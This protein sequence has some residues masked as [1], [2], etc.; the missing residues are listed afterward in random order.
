MG[1][2]SGCNQGMEGISHYCLQQLPLSR[3]GDGLAELLPV[4][5]AVLIPPETEQ[6]VHLV[7]VPL[8]LNLKNKKQLSIHYL[9]VSFSIVHNFNSTVNLCHYLSSRSAN[10]CCS[11]AGRHFMGVNGVSGIWLDMPSRSSQSQETVYSL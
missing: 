3:Q 9:F 8:F 11:F 5:A 2:P 1:L 4:G 7:G 6:N 10:Y